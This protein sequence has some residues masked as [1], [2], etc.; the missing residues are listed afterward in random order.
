MGALWLALLLVLL[1][2]HLGLLAWVIFEHFLTTDVPAALQHRIKFRILHCVFL[3]FVTLG[4][5]LE[6]L[7]ICSMPKF[8]R[9]F[10]DHAFSRRDPALKIT[11]LRF[12]TIRVRLYQPKAESSK[13]RR[14]ILF[15]HGGGGMFGGLDCFYTVC[16]FLARETDSVLLAVGYRM[17]PD[18]GVLT[19]GQ[20]SLNASVYFMKNLK[21]Y[22][23][24][25]N[26]VLVCGESIGGTLATVIAQAFVNK[27]PFLPDSFMDLSDLPRIRA[28]IL[29]YPFLQALN[30]QLPSHQQNQ[31]IPFLKR[32]LILNYTCSI[33]DINQTWKDAIWKGEFVPPE[34]WK[35]Y[36]KWLSDENIP[37]K[38]KKRNYRPV[39]HRTFNEAAYLEASRLCH[40]K[41]SP[42]TADDEVIAQL[43]ETFI[44]S[45][46]Y[47]LV[48][49]DSILY[50]K[51]LE[52]H[53]VPVT[54]YHVE[55]GFHA[56]LILFDKKPFSFPCSVEIMNAVVSYIKGIH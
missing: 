43:P 11:N 33:M 38:F 35:K 39:T 30:F 29:I 21:N 49:D 19:M 22:G 34:I 26:R 23:V 12:G 55:D 37:K 25:P 14:G 31:N 2:F 41:H 10:Q 3:Y 15:F 50:K 48:R 54:W 56:S 1:F 53:G 36:Q 51:R 20:D 5:I 7:H 16:C 4:S 13:P 6:K 17:Y 28:Q 42:L 47:D 27:S 45:C 40:V 9:F 46:E 32:K 44:L 18:H 52:D 24:D 8:F